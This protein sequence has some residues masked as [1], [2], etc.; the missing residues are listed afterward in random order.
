MAYDD[1]APNTGKVME[2]K[3]VAI[4]RD[5][6]GN[7]RAVSSICTHMGCDVHWND[8]DKVWSCACHGSRFA[9][10]GEVIR[11]PATKRLAFVEMPDD[12]RINQG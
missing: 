11:G 8:H 5:P 10:S 2:D 4:Y 7:L 3:H 1:I 6:Q 9:P 12:E